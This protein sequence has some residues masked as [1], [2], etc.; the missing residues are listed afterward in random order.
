[1]STA[2]TVVT[3][4]VE[5]HS[6]TLY[7]IAIDR[8]KDADTAKDMVQD[9]FMTAY[10]KYDTYR[11]D[12]SAKTWLIA[13]LKNKV[14]DYYRGVVKRAVVV[15]DVYDLG[16]MYA[17][18]GMWSENHFPSAFGVSENMLDNQQFVNTLRECIDKLPHNLNTAIQLK[19]YSQKK[20]QDICQE[21]DV[22]PTNLWQIL[23]RAKVRLR[24]CLDVNWFR[25]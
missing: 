11:G 23:H 14:V 12:S 18:N 2:K 22:T 8:L 4:W 1:M 21:L 16:T 7:A 13:I 10:H 24:Q 9:T 19:Y 17:E 3:T 20:G 5:E 6:E 15:G 25:L